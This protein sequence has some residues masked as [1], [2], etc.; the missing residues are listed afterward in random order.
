MTERII[1]KHELTDTFPD[2]RYGPYDLD[3]LAATVYTNRAQSPRTLTDDQWED[4]K[5]KFPGSVKICYTDVMDMI[6]EGELE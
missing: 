2:L 3:R 6:E 4:V 5:R 1:V